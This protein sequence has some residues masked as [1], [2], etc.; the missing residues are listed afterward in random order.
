MQYTTS[1]ET[2]SMKLSDAKFFQEF[3]LDVFYNPVTYRESKD[4]DELVRGECEGLSSVFSTVV[5]RYMCVESSQGLL[6][7]LDPNDER[8]D[9]DKARAKF[10]AAAQKNCIVGL[11]MLGRMYD[12]GVSDFSG[13]KEKLKAI[14]CY[15]QV[16]CSNENVGFEKGLFKNIVLSILEDYAKTIDEAS[17]CILRYYIV[18]KNFSEAIKLFSEMEEKSMTV[19]VELELEYREL[20]FREKH[21]SHRYGPGYMREANRSFNASDV[22]NQALVESVNYAFGAVLNCLQPQ[23]L[24]AKIFFKEKLFNRVKKPRVGC[25]KMQAKIILSIVEGIISLIQS[26]G[27]EK[28]DLGRELIDVFGLDSLFVYRN[29]NLLRLLS[30]ENSHQIKLIK[31]RKEWVGTLLPR[32]Y[33]SFFKGMAEPISLVCDL[34]VNAP[35]LYYELQSAF[36]TALNSLPRQFIIDEFRGKKTFLDV[37]KTI[38]NREYFFNVNDVGKMHEVSLEKVRSKCAEMFHLEKRVSDF[39]VI[40][41]KIIYLLD[42]LRSENGMIGAKALIL[43]RQVELIKSYLLSK[44]PMT[45]QSLNDEFLRSIS[46]WA[47]EMVANEWDYLSGKRE[48]LKE[49]CLIDNDPDNKDM[50]IDK[51]KENLSNLLREHTEL[52]KN[53]LNIISHG[54]LKKV[55]NEFE[56]FKRDFER[57][58]DIEMRIKAEFEILQI[59]ENEIKLIQSNRIGTLLHGGLSPQYYAEFG[60]DEGAISRL[61]TI[62]Q[63]DRQCVDRLDVLLRTPLHYACI[64]RNEKMVKYLVDGCNADK[65]RRDCFGI[66]ALEYRQLHQR[67]SAAQCGFFSEDKPPRDCSGITPPEHKQPHEGHSAASNF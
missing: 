40:K 17:Y 22:D 36:F 9:S 25:E 64:A 30:D 13:Q 21:F 52:P 47:Q 58:E 53:C 51:Y 55:R 66:T 62:I 41:P 50:M 59:L 43:S 5:A 38:K 14:Q 60:N 2:C 10:K 8:R 37:F 65:T 54:V 35:F 45:Q 56:S 63:R 31:G 1:F 48:V 32:I 11:L 44:S 61:Y 26:D 18:T 46:A 19:P 20:E 4:C 16:L 23:Y 3:L 67:R 7:L 28:R 39:A 24:K 49:K 6:L 34:V 15:Y 12:R 57:S 27:D 29:D 42:L 33:L